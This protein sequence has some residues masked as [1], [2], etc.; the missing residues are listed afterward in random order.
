MLSTQLS[1]LRGALIQAKAI[2]SRM[3]EDVMEAVGI[4]PSEWSSFTEDAFWTRDEAH[5]AS[6]TLQKALGLGF[7]LA[8]VPRIAILGEHVA[9][10]IYVCVKPVNWSVMCSIA[11]A[12]LDS[13][14]LLTTS[15]DDPTGHETITAERLH[16]LVCAAAD[17]DGTIFRSI[18]KKETADE[19]PK[20]P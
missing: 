5:Q 12:G 7:H 18:N 8:G 11:T 1:A 6:V 2:A 4:T 20:A 14:R 15:T 10:V 17:I 3:T 19:V 16:A 13:T 9:T